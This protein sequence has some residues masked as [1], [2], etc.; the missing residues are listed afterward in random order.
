MTQIKDI[1]GR[2]ISKGDTVVCMPWGWT[3]SMNV[4]RVLGFTDGG[5]VRVMMSETK[6]KTWAMPDNC[7]VTKE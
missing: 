1:M 2:E 7:V 3:G 6:T 5:N 4:C